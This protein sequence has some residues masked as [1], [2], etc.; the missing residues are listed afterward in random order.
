MP[1]KIYYINTYTYYLKVTCILTHATI[2]SALVKTRKNT[3][4]TSQTFLLL[5]TDKMYYIITYIPSQNNLYCDFCNNQCL[6]L[7]QEKWQFIAF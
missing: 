7:N 1:D 2:T 4:L 3:N 6:S 5:M